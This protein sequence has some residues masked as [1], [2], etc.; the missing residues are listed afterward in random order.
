MI[1]GLFLC[2]GVTTFA[3]NKP[4]KKEKTSCCSSDKK[5]S[6]DSNIKVADNSTINDS[7]KEVTLEELVEIYKDA[8]GVSVELVELPKN[9]NEV[10][11]DTK[12][13]KQTIEEIVKIDKEKD[14]YYNTPKN[15]SIQKVK[16]TTNK[17]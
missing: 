8:E 13:L 10:L 6:C 15:I 14:I 11:V 2:F 9:K 12:K 4:A 16:A 17:K 3:Q 5:S 1:L 7:I